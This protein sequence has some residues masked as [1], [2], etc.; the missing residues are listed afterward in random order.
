MITEFDILFDNICADVFPK[1]TAHIQD[2]CTSLVEGYV[3]SHCVIKFLENIEG[4]D[5]DMS[6]RIWDSYQIN[7][8]AVIQNLLNRAE[9]SVLSTSTKI[10]V[11]ADKRG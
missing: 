6:M 11:S 3:D 9:A 8:T 1:V 2:N 5:S 7:N 10:D 4:Y